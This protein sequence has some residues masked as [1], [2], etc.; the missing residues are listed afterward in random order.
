MHDAAWSNHG[1]ASRH[2]AA[3]AV[4]ALVAGCDDVAGGAV[5]LSWKLRP[6]ASSLD[7]KFVDCDSGRAGTG[8]ITAIRLHWD[9][10]N[11]SADPT[12]KQGSRAWECDDSHGVTGFEL[13]EGTASLWVTPECASGPARDDT[14]LAPATVQRRVIRGDAVSLSAVELIVNVS[15]C[16]SAGEGDLPCICDPDRAP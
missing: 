5:E 16:A 6:A 15:Y 11:D 14:Y 10:Q 7:N 9:V 13:A 4:L 1:V 8:P 12:G 3:L 2:L